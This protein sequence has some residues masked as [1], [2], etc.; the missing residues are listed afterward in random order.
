MKRPTKTRSC[1]GKKRH[2]SRAAARVHMHALITKG[3]AP[4]NV[5]KCRYCQAW[6]VGHIRRYRN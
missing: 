1:E 4:L 2:P 5:Y 3:A 6:H